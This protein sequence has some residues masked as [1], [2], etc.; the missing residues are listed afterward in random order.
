VGRNRTFVARREA[1]VEES[2]ASE[3]KCRGKPQKQASPSL[4]GESLRGKGTSAGECRNKLHVY[5]TFQEETSA[6]IIYCISSQKHMA[7]KSQIFI[8]DL[9]LFS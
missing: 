4:L 1:G 6:Y 7:R 8:E 3:G 5:L 9:Q 2:R